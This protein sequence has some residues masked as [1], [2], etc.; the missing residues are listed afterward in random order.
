M[1]CALYFYSSYKQNSTETE[2]NGLS[3]EN[4][5]L[6]QVKSPTMCIRGEKFIYEAFIRSLNWKKCDRNDDD[7]MEELILLSGHGIHIYFIIYS[8]LSPLVTEN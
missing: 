6:I 3:A 4:K 7:F 5:S 1:N 2:L 8:K